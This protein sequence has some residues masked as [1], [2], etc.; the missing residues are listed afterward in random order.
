MDENNRT[1][2]CP[3]SGENEDWEHAVPCEN[4]KDNREEW[5]KQ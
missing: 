2:V 1:A 3:V 4:N 5:E